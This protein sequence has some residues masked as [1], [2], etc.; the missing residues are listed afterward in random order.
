MWNFL[1]QRIQR[2]IQAGG[3]LIHQHFIART[4]PARPTLVRGLAVDLIRGS[5]SHAPSVSIPL[6]GGGGVGVVVALNGPWTFSRTRT[7]ISICSD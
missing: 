7:S 6:Y 2:F 3:R 5:G 1:P 4:R